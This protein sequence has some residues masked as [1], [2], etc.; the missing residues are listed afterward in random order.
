MN[1]LAFFVTRGKYSIEEYLNLSYMEKMI[2]HHS[3]FEYYNEESEKLKA[4]AK[5]LGGGGE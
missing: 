4:L 1:D 5:M 2:L 3:R